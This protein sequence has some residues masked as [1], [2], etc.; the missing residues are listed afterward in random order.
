MVAFVKLKIGPIKSM[1]SFIE[2][3]KLNQDVAMILFGN[4]ELF[5]SELITADNET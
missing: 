4:D 5:F 3:A 1:K 2:K